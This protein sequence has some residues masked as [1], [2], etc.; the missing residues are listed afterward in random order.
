MA[1]AGLAC[2]GSSGEDYAVP[3]QNA[4]VLETS[5]PR[6]FIGLYGPLREHPEQAV[7]L[8]RAGQSTSRRY[9]WSR[10]VE[11]ALLPRVGLA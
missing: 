4:L 3:G 7:R 5:E 1:V 11:G 9:A 2:T 8:R 10:V 6:E